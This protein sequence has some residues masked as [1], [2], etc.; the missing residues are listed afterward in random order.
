MRLVDLE[1]FC[2]YAHL[3]W[4]IELLLIKIECI[5]MSSMDSSSLLLL[6]LEIAINQAGFINLAATYRAK[7]E[8]AR[9]LGALRVTLLRLEIVW[10]I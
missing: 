4:E 2:L 3:L 10:A 6:I 8:F 1:G 5:Y 9:K 7:V